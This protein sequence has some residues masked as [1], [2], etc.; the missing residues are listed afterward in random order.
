MLFSEAA[1]TVSTA[2]DPESVSF[3]APFYLLKQKCVECK[4]TMEHT[5]HTE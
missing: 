2:M 3:W 4:T 5:E 1:F